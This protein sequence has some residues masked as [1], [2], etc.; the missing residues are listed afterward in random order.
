MAELPVTLNVAF[1]PFISSS[2]MSM[3]TSAYSMS[4]AKTKTVHD[5]MNMSMALMYETGGS[6]FCD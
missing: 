3:L 6:D 1:H 4:E 2:D 5:D